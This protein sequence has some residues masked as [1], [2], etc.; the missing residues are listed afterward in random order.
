MKKIVINL[1]RRPDRKKSFLNK[2]FL[3]SDV[4]FA[5]AIDGNSLDYQRLISANFNT[6]L[7]YVDPFEN[8]KMTKGEVACFLSHYRVWETCVE[9]NEPILIFEDDAIIDFKFFN[10]EKYQSILKTYGFVY[11]GRNE[12]EKWRVRS[13]N[14]D[15]EVPSYS[16]NLHAY[17]ITPEAA[18]ILMSTDILENIIPVDEYLPQMIKK[19]NGVA[20]TTNVVT[21]ENRNIAGS[22]IEPIDDSKWFID[23]NYYAIT[24]G[25][26]ENQCFRLYSSANRNN[27][28]IT[29]IGKDIRW[30]GGDTNGP[31]CG[32]KINLLKNYLTELNDHDVIVF[33]DAYDVF[34]TCDLETIIR[35]Y[36][37]FNTRILFSAEQ[38]CWP[39]IN[40]ENKFPLVSSKYRYLNSG[41]FVAQVGELK[42]LLND[43]IVDD[44]DDQLYYQEKFLSKIYDIKLDYGCQIFQ[45]H[46]QQAIINNSQLYNP[47]NNSYPCIYHGN[48]GK[49]CKEKFHQLYEEYF[50]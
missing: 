4:H 42:R 11:L 31:S 36:L 2:N 15:I 32:L 37:S 16:H 38:F 24:V 46:E 44:A 12:L 1:N 8:R 40:L 45:T 25:T 19:I 27:I 9:L 50:K 18:K 7:D 35:K 33:T 30:T 49:N 34:Y 47:I 48:G 5:E 41:G 23:F 3:L 22:D 29:N 10:E 43:H 21:Q 14:N 26:D 13:I 17:G 28:D 6:D 39:N 20:L